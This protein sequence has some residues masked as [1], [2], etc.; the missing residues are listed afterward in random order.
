GGVAAVRGERR[1]DRRS[2][3]AGCVA[4]IEAVRGGPRGPRQKLRR[5]PRLADPRLADEA[6]DAACPGAR[7]VPGV[8][9]RGQRVLAAVQARLAAHRNLD[10]ARR[11]MNP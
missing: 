1:T 11:A 3:A 9:E 2:I 5:Q 6:N 4:P 10:G 7:A 8:S